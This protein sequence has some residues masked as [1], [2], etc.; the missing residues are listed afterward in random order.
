MTI[1]IRN[2]ANCK[3][4]FQWVR[5][6]SFTKKNCSAECH[7]EFMASKRYGKNNPAWKG[8]KATVG[9]IHCWVRDNFTRTNICERCNK[10]GN[11]DWSNKDHS[12]KRKK[13]DWQELCRSCH[14]F[15][16][17]ENGLRKK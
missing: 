2:C 1:N 9:S 3:K 5:G 7:S 13:E 10:K 16:D 15:Y 4:D 14:Q 6:M 12:Y 17:Y 8:K 11:T